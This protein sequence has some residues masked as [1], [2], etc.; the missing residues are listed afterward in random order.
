LARFDRTSF[1][2][3]LLLGLIGVGIAGLVSVTRHAPPFREV[4]D[5]A[6]LEIYALQ[7]LEGKLW[8]ARQ[9]GILM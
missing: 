5:R 7:A 4:S 2:T 3:I 1:R 6:I 8:S 9:R